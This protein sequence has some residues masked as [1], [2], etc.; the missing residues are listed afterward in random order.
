MDFE[1]KTKSMTTGAGGQGC[2]RDGET[3]E[4]RK[5][6]NRETMSNACKIS[7]TQLILKKR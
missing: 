1:V 3:S 4:A 5:W 6:R 2:S 7:G